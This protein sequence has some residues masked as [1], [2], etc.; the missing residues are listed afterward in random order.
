[1]HHQPS[2]NFNL[3]NMTVGKEVEEK[4]K[5]IMVKNAAAIS[6]EN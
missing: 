1:M 3:E 2:A 4:R 6:I 5:H